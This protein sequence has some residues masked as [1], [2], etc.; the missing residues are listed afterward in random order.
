MTDSEREQLL[1]HLLGALDEDEQ[2]TLDTLLQSDPEFRKE[3]VLL[4]K[5]L[6]PLAALR[7]NYD[8]P[9]GLAERT[10]RFVAAHLASPATALSKRLSPEVVPPTRIGRMTKLDMV[11]SAIVLTAASLLIFPA[12]ANS[13]FSARRAACQDN[14]RE[15]G[16]ALT[17]YSQTNGGYFPAVPS[18]GKLATAGIYAPVLLQ[19]KL[20][21]DVSRVVCPDSSLAGQRNSF[22]IPTYSELELA[23]SAKIAGLRPTLGGSYGY[24]LGYTRD[25]S[26]YPTKNLYRDNFAVMSDSPSDR[27]DHQS[28]NHGGWGQN[29]LF[30]NNSVKF[31]T[32]SRPEGSNDDIF[33]NDAGQV[34][35]GLQQNDS[36][37]GASQTA[38]INYVNRSKP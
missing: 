27:L 29:V 22:H 20:I 33:T 10:C 8:S 32:R 16:S 19:N 14:L 6:E 4:R 36:V 37:I 31:V 1:G 25:G 17:Q 13:R 18:Q 11:M 35:A 5:R 34:A 15:L 21:T 30:E 26:Y 7:V 28:Q 3:L 2:A 24:N 9:P 23:P 12:V 38:P